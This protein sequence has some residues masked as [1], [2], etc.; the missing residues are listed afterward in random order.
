MRSYP[1]MQ[2]RHGKL[3]AHAERHCRDQMNSGNS[4]GGVPEVGMRA[5]PR[6]AKTIE[7][8]RSHPPKYERQSVERGDDRNAKKYEHITC[9]KTLWNKRKGHPATGRPFL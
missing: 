9:Q 1:A 7:A 5:R 2:A 8:I 3:N 6:M 4:V